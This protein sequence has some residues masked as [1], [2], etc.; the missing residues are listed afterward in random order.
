MRPPRRCVILPWRG[1]ESMLPLALLSM[2]EFRYVAR[3][4]RGELIN[5]SVT[6]ADRAGAILQVERHGAVPISIEMLGGALAVPKPSPAA[7][8]AAKGGATA[9]SGASPA[10]STTTAN[11]PEPVHGPVTTL[12]YSQQH[13]FTEQLAHLLSAGMTLD[14]SL[15]VLERR[16]KHPRLQGLSRSLH[17][18]LVDG[19]SLSQAMRDFPRIFSPLYVNLIS[20]GEASGALPV[21]LNRLVAHLATIKSLRDRV[22][23][24]LL[25]P[26]VLVVAGIGLIVAFMTVMVPQIT[27]FFKGTGQTLPPATQLLINMNGYLVH[28]G[29]LGVPLGLAVFAGYKAFTQR[30]EGR[31][32]WD[33]F[34]W[35]MPLYGRIMRYRFYAQFARTLGTLMENGVTMLRA[36]ELLEQISGNAY[37]AARTHETRKAVVDGATLS[38]ALSGQGLFPELFVDMLAVGEQTGKFSSTM[39]MI[40]NVYERELDKQVQIVSTLIPPLVMVFIAAAVGTVVYGIMSAVFGLTQN[41]R[42]QMH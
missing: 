9:S 2:P 20:A 11:D 33:T 34:M 5:G 30:P 40:A 32:I 21:I 18:A 35:N 31:L 13:L 16:L 1:H 19:L 28:Y 17:R 25:Y 12:S 26:A 7:K 37:V 10:K 23:Q 14:E 4:S 3:D 38:T 41:L 6:C 8:G 36:L 22:Q 39:H 15:A 27:K 29:W 42:V 24:A